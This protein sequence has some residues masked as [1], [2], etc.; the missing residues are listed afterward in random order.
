MNKTVAALALILAAACSKSSGNAP[1]S[2]AGGAAPAAAAP[3]F[4]EAKD[5]LADDKVVAGY[6]AYQQEMAPHTKAALELM[7][8]AYAKAGGDPKTL[9]E[10]AKSDP[11]IAEY[12]KLHQA[13]LAKAGISEHEMRTVGSSI[14]SFLAQVYVAKESKDDAQMKAAEDAF[15]AQYGAGAVAA[16]KKRLPELIAGQE[17]VMKAMM[18]K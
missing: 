3:A 9:E 15:A 2:A 5:I 11:R 18:A 6:A 13:A 12:N 10:A 16:V 4:R 17:A 1:S 14:G 8:T 7:S